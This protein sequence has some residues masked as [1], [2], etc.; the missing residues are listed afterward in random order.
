MKFPRDNRSNTSHALRP[1]WR[2]RI[3]VVSRFCPCVSLSPRRLMFLSSPSSFISFL[4]LSSDIQAC[5]LAWRP[6]ES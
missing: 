3:C 2:S 6:F 4:V 5:V 1:K